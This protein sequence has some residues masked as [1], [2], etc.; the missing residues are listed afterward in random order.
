[1]KSSSWLPELALGA[2]VVVAAPP[3]A[4]SAAQAVCSALTGALQ[5]PL[6]A[7]AWQSL[8]AF[9]FPVL[10]ADRHAAVSHAVF[11]QTFASLY[12]AAHAEPC[13]ESLSWMQPA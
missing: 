5:P 13:I 10:E 9:G 2:Q 1:M 7:A 3:S 11:M 6:D 12:A 4:K 8:K